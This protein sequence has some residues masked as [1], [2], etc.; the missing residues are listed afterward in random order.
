MTRMKDI[1][2]YEGLY[3]IMEDGRVWSYPKD[4]GQKFGNNRNKNGMWMNPYNFNGYKMVGL[5]KDK[6]LKNVFVH[7]LVAIAYIPNPDNKSQINHKDGNPINNHVSNLE[8][9]TNK[10]N[11][12]HAFKNRM[13]TKPLTDGEIQEIRKI[14][15]FY[16]LRKIS[17][18]YGMNPGFAW[19]IAKGRRYKE[20]V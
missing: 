1:K 14:C 17:M 5:H 15:G 16:S 18:A 9:V 12:D 7:R 6:M 13:I 10:E 8:W 19:D 20:V 11:S 2:D 4:N 3:A